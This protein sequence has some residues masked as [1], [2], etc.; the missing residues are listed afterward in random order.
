MKNRCRSDGVCLDRI[1]YCDG[2]PNCVDGSDEEDCKHTDNKPYVFSIFSN[3]VGEI[4]FLLIFCRDNKNEPTS[5]RPGYFVCDHNCLPQS[6]LCDGKVDCYTYDDEANCNGTSNRYYQIS[7]LFPYK[8][9]MTPTSFLIFWYMPV[10][11]AENQTFEYLPSISLANTN[12]WSNYTQWIGNTQHRFENLTPFT[13]YNVTV[14]VRVNG[15]DHVDPPY[16]YINVTTSEGVPTEPL[17]VNVT[18]LNGSRVQISWDPPAEAY[19]IL[20]EYTVYYRAQTKSVQQAHSVKVSPQEHSIVLESNFEPNNTYEYWVRAKNSKNE[21]PS[22]KLVRLSFDNSSDMDRLSGLHV[23]HI[24]PDYIQ[25]EWNE[26]KGVDGYLIQTILPQPYPKLEPQRTKDMKFRVQNLV[27]GVNI[28]IKV[29]GFKKNYFGRPASISSIL[30]GTPLPEVPNISVKNNSDDEPELSWSTPNGIAVKNITYGI[31]YGTTI[32]E[33]YEKPRIKTQALSLTIKDLMPCESYLISVGIVAPSG[34]GPLSRAPKVFETKY[35]EKKPPRNV[36]A[37]MNEDK[38]ELEI[39][40]AHNC[41]LLGTYPPSYLIT[42]T[43]LMQNKTST[44]EVKR[45]GSK[46]LSHK[47]S[48]IPDGA[49]FNISISTNAKNAEAITLKVSA[50][51]LPVVRQLKVYPE[52]NGTYVIYWH[53]VKDNK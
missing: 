49:V 41:P 24:G 13:S 33:L 46:L 35:N 40:W 26:I 32:D 51:P 50:P 8:R 30:P 2:F 36:K 1:K 25:V 21:S 53:H 38:H 4:D 14:Y 7:Y 10:N 9:T 12:D 11:G 16:L 6:K 47:F 5:C 20:K 31:Y 45:K 3:N 27:Q 39:T 42:L 29:A 52:K 44:V 15:S 19:G 18:Q 43:E 23:T 17:N 28:N 22:S 48:S 34:P 37:I